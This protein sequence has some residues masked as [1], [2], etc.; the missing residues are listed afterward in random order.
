MDRRG[1]LARQIGLL[2]MIPFLLAV[3][4]LIG[5]FM[6][7]WLDGRL[8]TNPVLTVVLLLLGF[9]AGVRETIIL[10]RRASA[11]AEESDRAESSGSDR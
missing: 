4:P 5:W 2:S 11:E 10:V 1:R 7:R 9:V 6:G 3:A 8:G